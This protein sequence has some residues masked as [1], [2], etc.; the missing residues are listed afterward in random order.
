MSFLLL[1]LLLLARPNWA[2]QLAPQRFG[3]YQR[4]P[5][6]AACPPSKPHD[7]TFGDNRVV[8]DDLYYLR[9]LRDSD[10]LAQ[11][12]AETANAER[13]LRDQGD[14]EVALA[15]EIV[16]IAG[17]GEP[18]SQM[19]WLR[20]GNA[21]W[22]P[23][24]Y[25]EPHPVWERRSLSG[26][27]V[28][29]LDCNRAPCT[30]KSEYG[31]HSYR[32]VVAG[33]SHAVPF[34]Q[35][36]AY[37]VDATG[38]EVYSIEIMPSNHPMTD[39]PGENFDAV[40]AWGK[41]ENEIFGCRCDD[42]GRPHQ[43]WRRRVDDGNIVE[44]KVYEESD[45]RFR[46]EGLRRTQD[47]LLLLA[48][49]RNGTELLA[50]DFST[51]QMRVV[52]PRESGVVFPPT[53][54]DYCGRRGKFVLALGTSVDG[55]RV[56]SAVSLSGVLVRTRDV[57]TWGI[58]DRNNLAVWVIEHD[59]N[60]VKRVQPPAGFTDVE[61]RPELRGDD[62]SSHSGTLY[63]EVSAPNRVPR[64]LPLYDDRDE[65]NSDDVVVYTFENDL[66]VESFETGASSIPVVVVYRDPKPQNLLLRA[67]GAYGARHPTA[68]EPSV[69]AVARRGV[70]VAVVGARGG[71]EK[72]E[73]WHRDGRG[74]SS[75]LNSARDVVEAARALREDSGFSRIV[76]WGRSAGGLSVG[77][78]ACL[79]PDLFEAVALDVPFLDPLGTLQDA[80]LP[81][82]VNEWEEFGNPHE[83]S[84]FEGVRSFSPCH[85][86]VS[87]AAFPPA[88]LRPA[89]QD[90]RT[91]WWESFKFAARARSAG[92]RRI[93][94]AAD[95]R[96]H[97]GPSS[98]EGAAKDVAKT[99]AF[100]LSELGSK[101]K[102]EVT[103]GRLSE[104]LYPKASELR[105][106][107]FSEHL[108]STGSKYLQSRRFE[109]DLYTAS[110]TAAATLSSGGDEVVGVADAHAV[111][112]KFWYISNVAVA[113]DFRRMGI[114]A[115]LMECAEVAARKQGKVALFLHVE[116]ANRAARSL[117]ETQGF[118]VTSEQDAQGALCTEREIE[119]MRER[120]GNQTSHVLYCKE[121]TY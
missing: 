60:I 45:Q 41:D 71:G 76:S 4:I 46:L 29:I 63:V 72:G 35:Y 8:V 84:S 85:L 90:A 77:G 2:L 18:S 95:D 68:L 53:A 48:E 118:S 70:A 28:A 88:L 114:G 22:R 98:R 87:S 62:S 96:G 110:F 42:T 64:L 47:G 13:E 73:S 107:T 36:L 120:C 55:V 108:T 49:S 51:S 65:M 80:S 17:E 58:D 12:D 100:L 115:K 78:A 1:L 19:P 119:V 112:A 21:W 121:L 56:P 105:T 5:L 14:L 9:D 50:Y 27:K 26:E 75:K 79:A 44:T 33:I 91:G 30:V 40:V 89:M 6:L 117:Y 74:P 86:V 116:D 24:T 11:L 94:V 37:T 3:S 39:T 16:A 15:S 38:D 111:G 82:T 106:Q 81:L 103:T 101:R 57:L 69:A 59:N 102:V 61:P 113:N 99:L 66:I 10:T 54:V 43:L 32:S 97:F 34:G 83:K 104:D 109:A 31:S 25:D 52:R 7:V 67:Y 20:Y 23:T 92:A 93:V